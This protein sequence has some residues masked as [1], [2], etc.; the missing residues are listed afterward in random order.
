M[1]SPKLGAI[2]PA[3]YRAKILTYLRQR[4]APMLMDEILDKIMNDFGHVMGDID[5][6]R[7]KGKKIPVWQNFVAHA[8]ASLTKKKMILTGVYKG[9]KYVVLRSPIYEKLL[10]QR[11]K[12]TYKRKCEK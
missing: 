5:L 1:T 8:L 7:I 9:D 11:K 12:N 4:K 10:R 2:P 6:R 3:V